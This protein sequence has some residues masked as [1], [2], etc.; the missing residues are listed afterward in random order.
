MKIGT[1]LPLGVHK[2]WKIRFVRPTRPTWEAT[3]DPRVEVVI[4]QPHR[5]HSEGLKKLDRVASELSELSMTSKGVENR[6]Y[7]ESTNIYL[8]SCI[9]AICSS[10]LD[11]QKYREDLTLKFKGWPLEGKKKKLNI[12]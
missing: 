6:I 12:L 10:Q 1:Y 4:E 8:G 2:E 9:I 5:H 3:V 7:F 11:H